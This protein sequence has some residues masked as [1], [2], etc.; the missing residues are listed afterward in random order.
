MLDDLKK[1]EEAGHTVFAAELYGTLRVSS[2]HGMPEWS[3]IIS[4][5]EARGW[6][7]T[8]W[9]VSSDEKGRSNAY[10]LFRRRTSSAEGS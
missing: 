10:P 8:N 3:E 7:L 4:A 1:V 6:V 2:T 5:V 9:S